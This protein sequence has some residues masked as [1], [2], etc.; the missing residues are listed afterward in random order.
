VT[1]RKRSTTADLA[2]DPSSRGE[3]SPFEA[4]RKRSPVL[5]RSSSF[6]HGTLATIELG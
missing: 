5:D 4:N 6:Y 3:S 1:G 2:K